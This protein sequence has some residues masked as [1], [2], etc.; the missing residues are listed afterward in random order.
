MAK[1]IEIIAEVGIN[2]GGDIKRALT[3]LDMAAKAGAD[4]VKFQTVNADAVYKPE[5]PL[6]RIFK[7][8]QFLP[9]D[10]MGLKCRAE[11][12]GV[13]F[14]STP[15]D[16]G[17]ADLLKS[18]GVKRFKIASDSAKDVDFVKYIMGFGKPILVSTGHVEPFELKALIESYGDLPQVVFHCVSKYPPT[19][20]EAD[21]YK[22]G[23]I[24]QIL[25]QEIR[26]G[27]SDHIP[28][29][30]SAVLAVGLGARVI[31][32]HVKFGNGDIDAPVSISFEEFKK[33]V[34]MIRRMEELL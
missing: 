7:K 10:W 16:R 5:D 9:G 3:M 28:W 15:G 19:S 27:Y 6:Y 24:R 21:L 34:K 18:I 32:K 13:E 2:H 17:S 1:K 11:Q 25:P 29:I 20:R 33:M 31:E 12:L 4:T 8:V 23:T 22:I 26:V 30:E 14:L